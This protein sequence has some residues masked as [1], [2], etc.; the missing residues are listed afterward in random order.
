MC[1]LVFGCLTSYCH[2]LDPNKAI[3]QYVQFELNDKNGL[4]QNSV[5][6]I[7]QTKDGYMWFGTEEGIARFDGLRVTVLNTLKNKKLVDNYI[8]VLTAA[9]DGSLWIG[10]RSGV[11]R[12]KDG[13]FRTYFT[14]GSPILAIHEDRSR[15]IWVGSAEGLYCL[16]NEHIRRYTTADNLPSAEIRAIAEDRRGTLWFG[17]P[18][19]LVSLVGDRFTTYTTKDGLS[20]DAIQ[21]LTPSRDGSLWV[22]TLAGLVHWS[23]GVLQK[24]RP[25]E[26]PPQ[27]RIASMLEDH[28]GV[29]WLAFEHNGIASLW[30]GKLK[31]YTMAEG[32]PSDE[33]GYLFED[34]AQHLWVGMSEGGAVELRDGLFSSFGRRE[35]LSSN[36]IWSVLQARDGSV[37]V[38]TN[39]KGLNHIDKDG[40]VR[41]YTVA[42]GLT[43]DTIFGLCEAPDGSLWIGLEHGQLVH[44]DRGRFTTFRDPAAKDSRLAAILQ[45]PSGDLWLGFHEENG[46]VRFHNGHFQHYAAPGLVNTLAMAP[47]GAIWVGSDHAGVS[48]M[49]NGAITTYTTAQG[50]LS[51]FAQAVYVD[52]EGVVWAG[53]SPGGLNRIKD[54]HVTTYSVNQGLFDLT[55]GAIVEDDLGN[56]WMTC[57]NGIF[58]VTKKELTDYA[59]GRTRSIHSVV[60]GSADGLREPECN[61]AAYPAVWKGSSGRL[62]FATVGGVAS[63]NPDHMPRLVAE[64]QIHIERV[65]L[66]QNPVPSKAE[67]IVGIGGDDLEVQFT[68]PEFSDPARMQFRYRLDRFDRDWVYVAG[69]REAY[70]TKLPPGRYTFQV[71]AANGSESWS[72]NSAVLSFVL[73][74]HYWQTT[75]FKAVCTLVFLLLCI[76]LAKLRFHYLE[77][78]NRDLENRVNLRTQELQEAIKVAEAATEA[79]HEQATKDSL[80]KL[81]NRHAIFELL[82]KEI[83]RS[84]RESSHLCVLMVDVDHFKVINDMYGH[85]TGDAVLQQVAERVTKH[86]RPYDSIGRYGGEELL[87]ALPRCTLPDGLRRAEEFRH[88]IAAQPFLVGPYVIQV[89]CSIGVAVSEGDAT[90]EAMIAEADSALYQAKRSGRNCVQTLDPPSSRLA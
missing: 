41:I 34:R 51:D 72:P 13:V 1:L 64:P 4:P 14:P 10:T 54:G 86:A 48:R 83:Q 53:T 31:F 43:A 56:L 74:P 81:W 6:S 29:L 17:T 25:S 77:A 65:L 58:R 62:W 63:I 27:A 50:L 87:I 45:D 44:F 57:N 42:D 82:D 18:K 70:Y 5:Y 47:D 46:L 19:G 78:R 28:D 85:L 67:A 40:K 61:F 71:Q 60:Y 39:G 66:N 22:A 8:N 90:V 16:K 20:G 59:E 55:V 33:V 88:A 79:L 35:G 12:Y 69:R 68:A 75:W 3:T 49:K 11:G 24:L 84:S 15:R 73:R 80:T 76:V 2:A 26:F 23:G 32:L 9:S 36:M 21:K 7:A 37:W 30:Q 38:G 52:R 89:T